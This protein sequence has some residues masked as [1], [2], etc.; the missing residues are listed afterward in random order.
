[1]TWGDAAEIARIAMGREKVRD[2]RQL[3]SVWRADDDPLAW[4][5]LVELIM[6]RA[7]PKR[8]VR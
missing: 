2:G 1:V 4:W 6:E 8:H 7:H 5:C 3:K